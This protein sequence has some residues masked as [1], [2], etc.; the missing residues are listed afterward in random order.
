MCRSLS[1]RYE[2]IG[3]MHR[4]IIQAA[5]YSE[6]EHLYH[7]KR[8]DIPFNMI[9]EDFILLLRGD[10]SSCGCELANGVNKMNSAI[11]YD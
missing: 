9:D 8:G 7:I 11:K 1:W 3:E 5:T 6:Q 10:C 4:E 2:G